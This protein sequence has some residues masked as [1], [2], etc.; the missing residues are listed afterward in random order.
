MSAGVVHHLLA[1]LVIKGAIAL[2]AVVV[3][4]AG[5]VVL[6]RRIGR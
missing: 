1:D 4:V 3:F 5:A 6:W 2:G